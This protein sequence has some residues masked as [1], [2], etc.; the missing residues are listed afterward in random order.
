MPV[1]VPI[2]LPESTL[3]HDLRCGGCFADCFTTTIPLAVTQAQFVEA[4]YTTPLFRAERLVLRFLAGRGSTNE[5]AS[6][7]A[8]GSRA[9]FAVWHV[10]ARAT[11]QILLTDETGRTSSWLMAVP[12][13]AQHVPST[14]LFFGSALKPRSVSQTGLPEFSPVFHALLGMHTIYSRHL[15]QAAAARLLSSG[16]QERRSDA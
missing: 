7:L 1:A 12:A 6:E 4:F 10:A 2:E 8:N 16:I 9:T 13:Q 3:L 14:R 11:D 15:L 5:Q